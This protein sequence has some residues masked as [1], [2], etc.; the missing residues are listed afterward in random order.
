MGGGE[1]GRLLREKIFVA[2]TGL[3]SD[4]REGGS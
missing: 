4:S 2:L 3:I 1:V